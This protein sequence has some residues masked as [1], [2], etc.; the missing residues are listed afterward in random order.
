MVNDIWKIICYL[1]KYN[2]KLGIDLVVV[3]ELELY[4]NSLI[5]FF[6]L[7]KNGYFV[8]LEKN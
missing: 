2:L 6:Y 5:S 4:I 3:C 7:W 8:D 1:F